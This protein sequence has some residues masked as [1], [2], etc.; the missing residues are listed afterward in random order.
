MSTT[1]DKILAGLGRAKASIKK[2]NPILSGAILA[3]LL[4]PMASYAIN[5]TEISS[6]SLTVS[7]TPIGHSD[8]T[9]EK[10]EF[11]YVNIYRLTLKDGEKVALGDF[12]VRWENRKADYS[13]KIHWR[14]RDN[15]FA[16]DIEKLSDLPRVVESLKGGK[17]LINAE[18]Y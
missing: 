9:N 13:S 5:D 7:V 16:Q 4:T 11:T 10:G 8:G 15:G 18:L 17:A 2:H 1:R 14:E 6:P 3:A 12:G